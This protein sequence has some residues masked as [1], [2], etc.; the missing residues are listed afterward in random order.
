M[1]MPSKSG[2]VNPFR[3]NIQTSSTSN[4]THGSGPQSTP[5]PG[6]F[7]GYGLPPPYFYS[8]YGMSTPHSQSLHMT[9]PPHSHAGV[10]INP[11]SSSVVSEGEGCEKLVV[12]IN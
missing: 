9:A 6:P 10:H 1:F 2:Q 11:R 4:I 8:P 7:H 3:E 12:Y 5:T